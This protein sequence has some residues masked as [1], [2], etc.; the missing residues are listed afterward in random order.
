MSSSRYCLANPGH[1]HVIY[2]PK[3]DAVTVDLSAAPGRMTVEWL[4]PA[5]GTIVPGNS[6]D[7]GAK[8]TLHCPFPGGAAL[9][10]K[11]GKPLT[12]PTHARV[13]RPLQRQCWRNPKPPV[14]D[15]REAPGY[16]QPT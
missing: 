3:G 7:G 4:P 2:L 14:P 11:A 10:L 6:I 13:R 5:G 1:E 16:K 8:R 15:P 12:F 9:Y